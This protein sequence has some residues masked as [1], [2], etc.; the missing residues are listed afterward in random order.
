M[1]PE[2]I[3]NR[4]YRPHIRYK[5]RSFQDA[6]YDLLI[7]GESV[8]PSGKLRNEMSMLLDCL[9]IHYTMT[10]LGTTG[11]SGCPLWQNCGGKYR[12]W[13]LWFIYRCIQKKK[14]NKENFLN[15][16]EQT[17]ESL[18]DPSIT[19][20]EFSERSCMAEKWASPYYSEKKILY[21]LFYLCKPNRST[22]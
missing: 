2:R 1:D 4:P 12:P 11:G 22:N 14:I 19:F 8:M 6:L 16:S 13:S 9:D 7:S 21:L 3:C 10:T 15:L 5:H 18:I 20:E 17:V